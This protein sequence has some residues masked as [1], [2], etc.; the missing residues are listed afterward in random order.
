M[1]QNDFGKVLEI[2]LSNQAIVENSI[3]KNMVS[4][5]LGGPGFA[6]DYLLKE[7]IYEVQARSERNPL[8]F[9]VGLLTGT[10]YP[11][12]GFYSVSARSPLTNIWGEG[13]SGGFFGAKLRALYNGLIFKNKSDSPVYL[14]IDNDDIEIKDASEIWGLDT[15]S[16]IKEI[17]RKLGKQFRIACIGPS[18]ERQIPLASIMND[19]GRAVGR[20]GMGA[21]MGLKKLKA[22]AVNSNKKVNYYD[23]KNFKKLSNRIFQEFKKS[24]MAGILHQIGTNGIDYFEMIADVPHKNWSLAKWRKVS[25]ISGYVVADKLLVKLV[26]CY[27][28]PF[29][30]GREVKVE[31]GK[32]KIENAAGLEYETVAAF[33]SMCLNSDIES[34]AYINNYC[35]CM[36]I[37]TIS[38]GSVVTFAMECYDKGILSEKDIGFPLEWDD[39]DAII[40]LTEMICKNE[41]IGK[42]LSQGVKRASEIIGKD[43]DKLIVEIKGLEV[44]MHDP[45]ANYAL[46]LQYAT[47]NRGAG[48]LRGFGS[49]IYS[50]FTSYNKYFGILVEIPIQARTVDNPKFA[51]DIAISQ[52]LSEI[53][54]ALGICRQTLS[55]GPQIIENIFDLLRDAIFY[56]TGIQFTLDEILRAGERIFNLKRVFNVKCGIT[57][58]D[59]RI[60]E[61]L[62]LS[63]TKGVAKDKEL[64]IDLMLNEYYKYRG[65]DESGVPTKDK[66]ME[67][68]IIEY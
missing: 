65:W 56:L 33:G 48:H 15:K 16:T 4:Y 55:S 26:P 27:L 9:M 49:D 40:K 35:N 1:A 43:S 32:Y 47:S 14:V 64:T 53:N 57:R 10:S 66:S 17:R 3:N 42:I 8:V 21:I 30:C 23:E 38:T 52:N 12:S 44:L 24:P 45:R 58:R 62:K 25:K 13:N 2:D 22:I 63:L 11:C 54:N 34:I 7:K 31:E 37:D 61:R 68:N 36:G 50:G 46:G 39:P 6:V 59:D 60:P 29:S 67:L 18:G 51:K 41:G 19:H 5:L 20:T 28:C